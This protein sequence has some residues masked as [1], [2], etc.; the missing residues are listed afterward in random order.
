MIL[1]SYFIHCIGDEPIEKWY[2][3]SQSYDFDRG[4]FSSTTGSFTQLVWKKSQR[5][6]IGIAYTRDGRS[7]Y[8]VARYYPA[9]NFLGEFRRNVFSTDC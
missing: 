6:G 3:G 1:L 8:V 9:G 2:E 5:L 4:D 7:A